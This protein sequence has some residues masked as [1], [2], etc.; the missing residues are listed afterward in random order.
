MIWSVII[1]VAGVMAIAGILVRRWWLL[2][3]VA[4]IA[5]V[6]VGWLVGTKQH[7]PEN[8]TGMLVAFATIYLYAPALLGTASGTWLG[9]RRVPP[10]AAGERR[11]AAA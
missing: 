10:K 9:R 11:S 8:T 1:V 4:A 5:A 3:V 2:A 6:H 7:D